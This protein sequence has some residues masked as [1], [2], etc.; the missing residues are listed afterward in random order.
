MITNNSQLNLTKLSHLSG[1]MQS[2]SCSN[3]NEM[4]EKM[5][6]VLYSSQLRPKA[7][8][9]HSLLKSATKNFYSSQQMLNI[10]QT[11]ISNYSLLDN[12]NC[13]TNVA[14]VDAENILHSFARSF[15]LERIKE[16]YRNVIANIDLLDKETD[17]QSESDFSARDA[18]TDF[19]VYYIGRNFDLRTKKYRLRMLEK[20]VQAER[21][22]FVSKTTFV[23]N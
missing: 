4:S 10:S 2:I 11:S 16:L 12:T 7:L 13:S 19:G 6:D 22:Q 9:K 23:V 21:M 15:I 5:S 17:S 20:K 18:E 14:D 3:L 1:S 8:F